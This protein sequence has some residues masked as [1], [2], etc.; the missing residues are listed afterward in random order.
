MTSDLVV[1]EEAL[2]WAGGN[3][4]QVGA[5]R[6]G[7][8]GSILIDTTGNPLTP[9]GCRDR[10]GVELGDG[11][12]LAAR[13]FPGEFIGYFGGLEY[14]LGDRDFHDYYPSFRPI[15]TIAAADGSSGIGTPLALAHSVGS[16][17]WAP[18]GGRVAFTSFIPG[19]GD[20]RA[21]V[22]ED[23]LAS[24]AR[25]A[26]FYPRGRND[27]SM[28]TTLSYS[29]DGRWLLISSRGE[30]S[31]VA[32]DT[33]QVVDLNS[34][35][36]VACWYPSAGPSCL[37]ILSLSHEGYEVLDL[38]TLGTQPVT[39]LSGAPF[40]PQMEASSDGRFL[41]GISGGQLSAE[42]QERVGGNPYTLYTVDLE[43]GSTDIPLGPMF[44]VSGMTR[45][46]T[47]PKWTV[48]VGLG[49][50]V[51]VSQQLLDSAAEF[52][53]VEPT[54]D[55]QRY[56]REEYVGCTL[57]MLTTAGDPAA[58]RFQVVGRK[59]AEAAAQ[60]PDED[61][62]ASWVAACQA[63]SA[64]PALIAAGDRDG[65][66]EALAA[67]VG[68][69]DRALQLGCTEAATPEA[70]ELR[71]AWDRGDVYIEYNEASEVL[72]TAASPEEAIG[73]LLRHASSKL[74]ELRLSPANDGVTFRDDRGEYRADVVAFRSVDGRTAVVLTVW[75]DGDP[76]R[77]P[78]QNFAETAFGGLYESARR[79]KAEISEYQ[80]V[81]E[82][83]D[84][85][86]AL[87]PARLSSRDID[88]ARRRRRGLFG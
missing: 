51:V 8:D 29:P 16:P 14:V 46:V 19:A 27:L 68:Y 88:E 4:F 30:I 74:D 73:T 49:G 15:P 53:P 21:V 13:E 41:A 47:H 42:E 10:G 7:H 62:F 56:I 64:A 44:P 25:R 31:L 76:E 9:A 35:A 54:A 60:L 6:A 63:S 66:R 61:G 50:R 45:L 26:V 69:H 77:L 80:L 33:L 39:S 86:E 78:F 82:L 22:Y 12:L 71:R 17:A 70:R 55:G 57:A 84:S 18:S 52:E 28:D 81:D 36:N 85:W 24:G 87:E 72:V 11:R 1:V 67:A 3:P 79:L 58:A 20:V 83:L 48:P 37:L 65:L 2:N 38:E 75:T 32:L 40:F 34:H 59:Y 5:E 23:E 43:N